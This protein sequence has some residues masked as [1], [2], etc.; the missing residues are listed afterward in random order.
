M[1]LV[2]HAGCLKI[3][4]YNNNVMFQLTAISLEYNMPLLMPSFQLY[5]PEIISDM[6]DM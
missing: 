6:D 3:V 4:R 1:S 2:D 5:M